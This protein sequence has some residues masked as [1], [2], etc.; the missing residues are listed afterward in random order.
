MTVEDIPV[1][2]VVCT[3]RT[4]H[5]T[6]SVQPTLGNCSVDSLAAAARVKVGD[7]FK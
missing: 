1:V 5:S 6:V 4:V 3:V 7:I 2:G